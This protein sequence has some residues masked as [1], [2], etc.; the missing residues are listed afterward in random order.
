MRLMLILLGTLIAYLV[1]V[2]SMLK[3][4]QGSAL[5]LAACKEGATTNNTFFKNAEMEAEAF[6]FTQ[7]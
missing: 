2:S 5:L 6:I 7:D 3:D 4:F 1:Y